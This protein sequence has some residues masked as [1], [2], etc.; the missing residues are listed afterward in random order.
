MGAAG[1]PMSPGPTLT[2]LCFCSQEGSAGII[3]EGFPYNT[4]PMGTWNLV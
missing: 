1:F 4:V 3:L 2:V